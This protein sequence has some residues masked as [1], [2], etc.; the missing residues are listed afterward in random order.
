M[1]IGIDEIDRRILY[2][3]AEEARHTSAPDIAAELDVSAPTIRNRITKLEENG[4]IEGYHAHINYERV[5]GRLTTQFTCSTTDTDRSRFAQR[6]MNVRGVIHVREVMAGRE[7]IL[8]TAIGTDT[9][10]ITRIGED[11]EAMGV[12]IED[13][14]LVHR[15]HYRPYAPFGTA[16]EQSTSPITNVTSLSGSANVVE[17]VIEGGA[18]I[19]GK[20]LAEAGEAGL[21]EEG[22]L[23]ITIERDEETITP[24]GNTDLKPGDRLTLLTRNGVSAETLHA[25]TGK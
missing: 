12:K 23:V 4:V 3:L 9:D 22:I 20:S 24:Q 10:E 21:L 8:V 18:P 5:E 25:L 2:R 1:G 14:D 13:Q 6:I 16:D 17:I 11:I 15:E 19:A 7:D